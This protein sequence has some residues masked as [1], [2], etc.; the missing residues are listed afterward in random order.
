MFVFNPEELQTII[1]QL[2]QA[3]YNHEQWSK[4]LVRSL[5]C[6]LNY[7]QR[8]LSPQA[9]RQCQFGEWYYTQAPDKLRQLPPFLAI[10]E[11]HTRMHRFAA[12][13]LSAS[14]AGETVLLSEY[15]GL[16]RSLERLGAQLGSLKRELDEQL[17]NRDPLTGASSRIGLLTYLREQQELVKRGVQGC[18]LVMMDI[19]SFKAI[20]DGYGHLSGDQVLAETTAF[21]M[22]RLRVYDRVFR[23]GGDEF[24]ICLP[25]LDADNSRVVVERL[26][27]ALPQAAFPAADGSTIN[28]T[29]SFGV[30]ELVPDQPVETT[31]GRADKALYAA[32]DAGRNCVR[33]WDPGLQPESS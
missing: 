23:Y 12:G 4:G 22:K 18:S 33:S 10:E 26:C 5:I 14:A 30:A 27:S 7:D 32:K 6:K 17:Y 24:L 13:L 19:D 25:G 31:L 11:E 15:D 8:D 9:H 1:W 21:L 2:G 3:I 20:N 29:A 16:A 28:V